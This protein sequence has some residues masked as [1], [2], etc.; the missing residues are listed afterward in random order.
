MFYVDVDGLNLRSEPNSARRRSIIAVLP[1]G[2]PV[3]KLAAVDD[4]WW[5]VA[6]ELDGGSVEGFV[7]S[8]FVADDVPQPSVG[9]GAI[10]T[11]HLSGRKGRRDLDG[12]R[13]YPLDE[14][15]QPGRDGPSPEE[16]AV[17][18]AE[19]VRY[20]DVQASPRYQR[21]PNTTFCNIYAYD[22]CYLAEV[23]LPRVWWSTRAILQ[24]T[25]GQPVS[26]RYDVTVRELNANALYEWL[27]HWGP[28]FGW[29][30]TV[31]LTELQASANAGS[32]ALIVARRRDR[33]R[34]GHVAAVVPEN[35]EFQA[36]RADAGVT[37]PVQSQAGASN[38]AFWTPRTRWWV[39]D[40]FD[41]FAFWFADA[42]R[43][44][45]PG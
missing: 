13:A 26:V 8:R 21:K 31:S 24:L 37:S 16:K 3:E 14:P 7:A 34:P 36:R 6:T 2:Q 41:A 23:Y 42:T 18:L 32:A 15:D 4:T 45:V 40:R 19:I 17:Q 38:H 11:V 29:V 22:F 39:A 28:A 33:N 12:L 9:G 1:R 5:R 35:D 20:L 25:S 43:D 44:S 30:R 27:S 10:P